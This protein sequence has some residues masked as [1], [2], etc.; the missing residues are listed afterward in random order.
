MA[1]NNLSNEIISII[2]DDLGPKDLSLL[3]RTARRFTTVLSAKFYDMAL[4]YTQTGGETVLLWA[5][6]HNREATFKSLL[7]RG[8]DVSIQDKDGD[9]VLHHLAT[10][11]NLHLLTLL[12]QHSHKIDIRN[13]K[14]E[15]PLLCAVQAGN[16]EAVDQLLQAGADPSAPSTTGPEGEARRQIELEFREDNRIRMQSQERAEEHIRREYNVR[17]HGEVSKAPLHFAAQ[18]GHMNIV[19]LLLNAGVDVWAAAYHGI[20]LNYAAIGEHE[21]VFQLL[22]EAGINA[23]RKD[24]F[25]MAAFLPTV[26]ALEK[27]S[28]S[29]SQ[30]TTNAMQEEDTKYEP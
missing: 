1:F 28:K 18:K 14:G 15:T 17:G 4:T 6:L 16:G 23:H 27:N 26:D 19:K 12:L 25:D 13:D 10:K 3:L 5:A 7:E 9:T 2:T 24:H 11:G 30:G 20:A 8:A 29:S 21:D 22:W